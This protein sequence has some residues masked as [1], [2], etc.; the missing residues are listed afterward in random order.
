MAGE[1]TSFRRGTGGV[2]IPDSFTAVR[3]RFPVEGMALRTV[4]G[5]EGRVQEAEKE[6]EEAIPVLE[7]GLL[8][9]AGAK[10]WESILRKKVVFGSCIVSSVAAMASSVLRTV[11]ACPAH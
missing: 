4:P 3:R 8:P 10:C 2:L 7:R 5:D 6:T 1:R 9:R 11:T